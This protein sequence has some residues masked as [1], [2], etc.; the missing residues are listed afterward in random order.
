MR[1]TPFEWIIMESGDESAQHSG[2][3][4]GLQ[5]GAIQAMPAQEVARSSD[6][7][8]EDWPSVAKGR[9]IS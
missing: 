7:N 1:W 4:G 9:L 8:P 5:I 2:G 6:E 3:K